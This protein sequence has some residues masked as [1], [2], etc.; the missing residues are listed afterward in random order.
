MN[1]GGDTRLPRE[2]TSRLLAWYQANKR[3]LPWRRD[4]VPYHVWLS[5]IMLQQTRVEAVRE[6]YARFLSA[7]PHISDLAAV[8][9]A[10]LMKLWQGLG[11]YSRARNLRRAAVEIMEHH[12][13]VFPRDYTAIRALP[14]V[15]DYTAGAIASICFGLPCPAVDGN[16]L[17]LLSRIC[18]DE[19][20]V[21]TL[22][23]KRRAA[24]LV[25]P[26]YPP[27]RCGDF[28][29]CLMELGATVCLPHGA[30]RCAV[31]PA[32]PFCLANQQ[33]REL[34]FPVRAPKKARRMEDL[35]VLILRVGD[36]LALRQRGAQ[37]LLA[38]LWELPYVAGH[39]DPQQA[40]AQAEAWDLAPGAISG[41]T[42]RTHIFTHIEWHMAC[43]EL[44]CAHQAKAFTWANPARLAR[45]YAL[46]RAFSKL[47]SG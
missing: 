33:G 21:D 32:A 24:A 14:G 43:Y 12:G 38:G 40:L 5:E 22:A 34:D 18:A 20:R 15:G 10:R 36:Q 11:Y 16:V 44:E 26:L 41:M 1:G 25:A 39:L 35:T 37:G 27:G 30:P 29:Q 31:C 42:T 8:D 47:I 2:M 23:A 17:R 3:D 19:S 46:P 6:Y 9:E 7:L 4:T 13:G 45:E 28:S